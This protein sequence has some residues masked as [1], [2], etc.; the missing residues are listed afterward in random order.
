MLFPRRAFLGGMLSSVAL[1]GGPAHA[2][3]ATRRFASILGRKQVGESYVKLSRRGSRVT[4]EIHAEL[5]I[6]ILGLIRFDYELNNVEVWQDGVLQEMNSLTNN[7]GTP[8][9]VTARRVSGGL[10]VDGTGFQGFVPGN[11]ATTSYFTADFLARPTW[12]SSQTG[13][14]MDLTMRNAG[15]DSFQTSE[16]A[17]DCTRYTVRGQHD[18]DLYY[19]QN[20]EWIG[21]SFNVVGRTAKI[22]MTDRGASFNAIWQG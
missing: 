3:G 22:Q 19:D 6:S 2:A 15:A 8:N 4:A 12:V 10:Q 14:V 7:N 17:L 1:S 5:H 13:S 18:I 21:S 11:P 16:G 9:S 20:H